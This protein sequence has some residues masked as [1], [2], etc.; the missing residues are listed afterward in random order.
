MIEVLAPPPVIAVRRLASDFEQPLFVADSG[1]DSGRLFV[2]QKTGLIRILDTATGAIDPVPLLDVSASITTEREGG[3]LG[4]VLAPDFASTSQF[5]IYVTNLAG[6]TEIR[7]YTLSQT[8]PD[9]ADPMSEDIILTFAQFLG[10]HNAGWIGFGADGYLYI[11][12]GDGGGAGDPQNNG[13]DS[14]NLLGAMLRIDP[15][16]D[17]FPN[18]PNRDY[19]IPATNPFA[20]AGGAP[21]IYAYGLRNPYRSSIDSATGNL[22]IG[23]VGQADLEE[24]NLIPNGV[25][26]LN[27]GWNIRE[28]TQEFAGGPVAGLTEPFVEYSHGS[29]PL[30]GNSVT[31]GLV[32]RGPIEQL[33]GEYI[34]GDF[35]TNNI[36]SINVD[37]LDF[38]TLPT[39]ESSRFRVRTEEFAPDVGSISGITSFG[40]DASGNLYITDIAGGVFV[41]ETE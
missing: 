16:V 17:E 5:Y 25:A 38:D 33:R 39:L 29:G 7:R 10:N 6:D 4:L 35:V 2:I 20:D 27:F 37:T 24:I 31:G 34:F 1:D 15:A 40:E 14:S 8:D 32:Y 41:V 26:G 12:S 36:W 22:Y 28:G 18:D 23:D 11:A 13:Q 21:E 3:L 19:G 30:E 9:Q